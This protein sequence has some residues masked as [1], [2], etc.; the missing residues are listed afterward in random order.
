[1]PSSGRQGD[2]VPWVEEGNET[3]V[4]GKG[5]TCLANTIT[6]LYIVCSGNLLATAI[7][8]QHV[9]TDVLLPHVPHHLE[10]EQCKMWWPG[11]DC[12]RYK[13]LLRKNS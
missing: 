12:C 10:Q 9:L 3:E 2:E 6:G 5:S 8:Q 7:Q 13:A 1:M 11:Q 4:V